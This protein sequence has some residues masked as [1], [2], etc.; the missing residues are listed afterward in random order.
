MLLYWRP[1]AAIHVLRYAAPA[2]TTSTL[3]RLEDIRRISLEGEVSHMPCASRGVAG[4]LQ[5]V[6]HALVHHAN[7]CLCV[8]LTTTTKS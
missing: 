2:A 6:P 4:G 7:M 8:V 5:Y 1:A 3:G